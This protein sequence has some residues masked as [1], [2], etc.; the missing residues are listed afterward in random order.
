MCLFCE[1]I[2]KQ[3][4]KYCSAP[5]T[6]RL[7][8]TRNK[9]D[10]SIAS[11]SAIRCHGNRCHDNRINGAITISRRVSGDADRLADVRRVADQTGQQIDNF[12]ASGRRAGITPWRATRQFL[13]AVSRSSVHGVRVR[14]P[15]RPSV[16]PWPTNNGWQSILRP[17][18]RV[19]A[20]HTK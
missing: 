14:P 7:D 11:A 12:P 1:V 9:T 19:R 18:R 8:P 16:A 13:R 6:R 5:E 20:R 4:K 17:R 15:V 2:N 3:I 10:P